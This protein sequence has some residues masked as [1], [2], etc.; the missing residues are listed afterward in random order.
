MWMSLLLELPSLSLEKGHQLELSQGSEKDERERSKE[1]ENREASPE[2]EMRGDRVKQG[3][4][5]HI[6]SGGIVTVI[7]VAPGYFS[8]RF[9]GN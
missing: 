9:V 4:G 2:D 5:F 7:R 1:E 3:E 6:T 8:L